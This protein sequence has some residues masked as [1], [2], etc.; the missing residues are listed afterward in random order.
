MTTATARV[1]KRDVRCP[2][3]VDGR[4][5]SSDTIDRKGTYLSVEE[6]RDNEGINEVPQ[7]NWDTLQLE[8]LLPPINGYNTSR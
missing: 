1:P 2:V 8:P 3:P 6:L 4:D 5:T 7:E